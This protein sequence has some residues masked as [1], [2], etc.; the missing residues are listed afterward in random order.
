MTKFSYIYCAMDF[1]NTRLWSEHLEMT[2]SAG[3]SN[4]VTDNDD[5]EK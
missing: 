1:M 4:S 5:S 3:N 2:H